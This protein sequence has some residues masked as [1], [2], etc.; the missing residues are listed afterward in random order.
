MKAP[1]VI[2]GKSSVSSQPEAA[3]AIIRCYQPAESILLLRRNEKDSD[4]WSGH[5]AFPGGRQE[6]QDDTIYATC[7]RETYEETG[8]VLEEKSLRQV[9]SPAMAGRNV[10]APILV[11]PY[12]FELDFQPH[13]IIE[14]AEINSYLW[15]EVDMFREKGRHIIVE[16]LPD[17]FFPVFPLKD[18]YLW[19]FTYGLL[20]S[21]LDITSP[22][23]V[24]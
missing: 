5:F 3:V 2:H 24:S 4:P 12:L 15:L 10:K 23:I 7:A 13:I 9:L 22:P 19:G 11:Q 1:P 16:V 21:A 20:C 14:E 18:Y 6:E 8:I 17:R